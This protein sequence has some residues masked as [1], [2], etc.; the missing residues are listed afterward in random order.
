MSSIPA[1]GVRVEV[2]IID[3]EVAEDDNGASGMARR[4]GVRIIAHN[5]NPGASPTRVALSITSKGRQRK[6]GCWEEAIPDVLREAAALLETRDLLDAISP[7]GGVEDDEPAVREPGTRPLASLRES[8]NEV[9]RTF[10]RAMSVPEIL[11]EVWWARPSSAR[12][13]LSRLVKEGRVTKEGRFRY[14]ARGLT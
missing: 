7:E 8:L 14:L 12:S 5:H 10:G 9:L 13:E 3:C 2:D 4:V 1:H 6:A 11:A